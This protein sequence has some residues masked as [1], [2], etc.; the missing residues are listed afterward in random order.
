VQTGGGADANAVAPYF[1]S[2]IRANKRLPAD[3]DGDARLAAAVTA[4]AMPPAPAT[5]APIPGWASAISGVT[6]VVSDNPLDLRTVRF[7]FSDPTEALV[8]LVFANGAGGEYR[9]GLDGVARLTRDA[10]SGHRAAMTGW[11]R[12][13][14]FVLDYNTVAR[15][16]D[17]VLHIAPVPNGL[18]IHLA[19]RDGPAN[20]MLTAVPQPAAHP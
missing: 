2:A 17:Y 5:P 11:W 4:A 14:S 3:P 12:K 15:I 13:N 8:Q 19:D 9:I 7:S 6:Y 16:D 1:A 20:A 18:S 10:T